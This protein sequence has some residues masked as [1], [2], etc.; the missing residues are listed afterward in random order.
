MKIQKR[1]ND[2]KLNCLF[3]YLNENFHQMY[4]LSFFSKLKELI[5]YMES[6]YSYI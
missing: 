6:I 2:T 4:L 3:S 5:V 1:D